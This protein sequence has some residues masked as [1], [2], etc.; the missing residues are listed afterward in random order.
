MRLINKFAVMNSEVLGPNGQNMAALEVHCPDHPDTP[1]EYR[2]ATDRF[3]CTEHQYTC[4]RTLNAE[5]IF[6]AIITGS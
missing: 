1:M 3:R 2:V 4:D 5:D 6:Q